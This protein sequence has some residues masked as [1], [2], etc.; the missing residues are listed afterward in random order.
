MGKGQQRGEGGTDGVREGSGYPGTAEEEEGARGETAGH[1]TGPGVFRRDR[2]GLALSLPRKTP[3]GHLSWGQEGAGSSAPP[4][5]LCQP[6]TTLST[7]ILFSRDGSK[8]RWVPRAPWGHI[9]APSW[10][11]PAPSGS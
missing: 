10:A 8:G 3:F 6:G 11:G 5:Q 4:C 9:P 1:G 2:E 7:W